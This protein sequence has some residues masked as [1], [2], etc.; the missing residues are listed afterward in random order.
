VHSATGI[1][2]FAFICVFAL[3][4]VYLAFPDAFHSLADPNQPGPIDEVLYWLA[5]LHFGRINGIGIPCD[6]PGVCDQ[7]IKAIWAIFGLAP[8]VMFLTGS[9]MWWNRVLRRWRRR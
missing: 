4:G 7:T 8:A 5:F 1:W 3:S 9:L 2:S 6:G